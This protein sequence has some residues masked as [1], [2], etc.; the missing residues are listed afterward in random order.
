[1]AIK[2][3]GMSR[4]AKEAGFGSRIWSEWGYWSGRFYN[5][6][7]AAGMA[8]ILIISI[9]QY[10]SV[11]FL[12]GVLV[13]YLLYLVLQFYFLEKHEDLFY[14]P[15][16]QFSRA[17]FFILTLTLLMAWLGEP[18][19]HGYLWLLYSLQLMIIGR[20]LSKWVFLASILEVWLLLAALHGWVRPTLSWLELWQNSD[21]VSQWTWIAL[22]GFVI[23][24]LLRNIDARNETIA[25]MSQI[26]TLAPVHPSGRE[27]EIHWEK[28]WGLMCS[29]W[30]DKRPRSG[31]TINIR[32]R[33]AC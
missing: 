27:A 1:M 24:Y 8:I 23:H 29:T 16:I 11:L 10:V 9:Y 26:N 17:Q 13:A 5:L 28:S 31:S 3:L 32:A 15:L 6:I 14:R 21:L 7:V 33:F 22:I 4:L 18:G 30:V 12:A 19:V 2:R 20:H 25:T